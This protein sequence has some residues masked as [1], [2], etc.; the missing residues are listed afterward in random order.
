MILVT[1]AGIISALGT[2]VDA[3][4]QSLLKG[5]SGIGQ[6]TH[7]TTG[8]KEFPVG[9]VAMSNEEMSR[10]LGAGYPENGLRTVLMGIIAA[11]EAV[12][13]A[14]LT[15]KD[16]KNAA[17]ISGT[18]VGGMDK[19]E[20]FFKSAFDSGSSSEDSLELKYNDCGYSTE[21]IA[22]NIGK[23][24]MVTTPS[25][26]C[27]SAANAI[28]LGANMI[29]AGI[30]DMAVV[31][32]SEALTRFHLNGFNSLMILDRE[33]CRPF[34]RDRRGINLGEG[35]A[36]IVLESEKSARERGAVPAAV[37]SGYANTCDAFHQTA[38]SENAEGACLAMRKA[39]EMAHLSPHDISYINA[40]GTGTP[41]NDAGELRAM[42]R[43]WGEKL[44]EFSSTKGFTG[45]TTSAS[46]AIEAVICLLVLR[47]GFLPQNLGWKNP[48][49]GHGIP[50][51]ER[52]DNIDISNVIDNSFGFGGNDSSL[53]F[54]RY[55]PDPQIPDNNHDTLHN[56]QTSTF[57]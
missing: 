54:S 55:I 41:D 47:H 28:I 44:P 34:D 49:N 23:F 39:M 26:A 10:I 53:I 18:T 3:T 38:T 6:I 31:G 13:S 16:I 52:R 33:N 36:Y 1:G 2:G 37:L 35:A 29:N 20:L 4:L 42:E 30:V 40:H 56:L 15:D 8:H 12:G 5:E 14:G 32:G 19:T 43:I 50:V 24:S 48:I 25:T 22:A 51:T 17:F 21:L 9:E 11:K 46:G 57:I 7:L 27:S 45:H